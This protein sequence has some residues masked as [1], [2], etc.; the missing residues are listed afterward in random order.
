MLS[1][2]LSEHAIRT[3][4]AMYDMQPRFDSTISIKLPRASI[5]SSLSFAQDELSTQCIS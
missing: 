1:D 4:A 2:K 5:T 3:I